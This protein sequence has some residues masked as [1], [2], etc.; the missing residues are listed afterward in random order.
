MHQKTSV[1]DVG[2]D[3]ERFTEVVEREMSRAHA[4]LAEQQPVEQRAPRRAERRVMRRLPQRFPAF[5][6]GVTLRRNG[7]AQA[8][9][10]HGATAAT[11]VPAIMHPM[12]LLL[13]SSS[14]TPA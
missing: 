10:E 3:L 11:A 9:H 8:G 1:E 12:E 5:A 2:I 6:L 4:M 13:L 14:R 7:G